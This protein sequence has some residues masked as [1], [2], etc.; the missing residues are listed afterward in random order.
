MTTQFSLG[1]D[2]FGDVTRDAEG[3]Y[4]PH[5]EVL[6]NVI[7]Q[8]VLA[9]EVGLNSFNVGE[10]HREDYAISAPDTVLAGLAGQ[11][12]QISLGTAVTILSS[13]DPVRVFQRFATLDAISNGRAEI[14]L[15]RGSFIESFPLFGFDLAHY[16][17]LFEEKL[18]LFVELLKQ[19]EV[20]WEGEHTQTIDG[21]TV[22]PHL[23]NGPLPTWVGVGGSPESV[24]R[25][26][27]H[28]LP[29]ILAIIGGDPKRFAP[30][31]KLHRDAVAKFG[32]DPLPLGWHSPGHVAETDEQAQEELWP[33]YRESVARIGAER[34]WPPPTKGSFLAAA[35]P[36]GPLFVGSPQTVAA[37]IIDTA[38]ALGAN[39][40]DLKYASGPLP[41]EQLMTSIELFGTKVAPIVRDALS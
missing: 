23:A 39:R 27:R 38:Q 35:G 37:K 15:G 21:I 2:T 41:H 3:N 40:F 24:V 31:A 10:H 36:E 4:L 9:D 12:K 5:H 28:N 7:A 14:T 13:E 20:H 17:E 22:Y 11:T 25:A 32:H 19:Q 34:G 1:L 26:A 33:H 8:G 29:M 16:E 6:R 30:F 18:E